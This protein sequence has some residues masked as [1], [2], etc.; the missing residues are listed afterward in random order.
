MKKMGQSKMDDKK[1][2]NTVEDIVQEMIQLRKDQGISQQQLEQLT[3]VRQPI[4]S[5]M[6]AGRS[7]PDI[8]TIM[9]L[10]TPLGKCLAIVDRPRAAP[11]AGTRTGNKS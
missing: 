11:S 6:E 8:D 7:T 9:R 1:T 4:I 3:G 5:R 2:C 10:L